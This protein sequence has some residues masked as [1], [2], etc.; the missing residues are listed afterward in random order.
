MPSISIPGCRPA[1]PGC[2]CS[3]AY[4]VHAWHQPVREGRHVAAAAEAQRQIGEHLRAHA[5]RVLSRL[6]GQHADFRRDDHPFRDA[7][8]FEPRVDARDG[9]GFEG[10]VLSDEFLNPAALNATDTSR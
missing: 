2:A 9:P 8:D 6:G 5:F 7:A 1:Y 3:I 10:D 4:P